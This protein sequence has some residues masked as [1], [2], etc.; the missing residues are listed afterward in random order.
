MLLYNFLRPTVRL[1]LQF[2]CKRLSFIGLEHLPNDK[3][4]LFCGSHSNSFLDALFLATCMDYPVY[5]LARGDAFRKPLVAKILREFKMLPIFRQSEGETD[6]FAKNEASFQTCQQLFLQNKK[7]LIYPEGICKHQREILPLKKGAATLVIRAWEAGIDLQIV[8]VGIS[9]DDYFKWGKK[10]DVVFGK[11]IQK[12][13]FQDNSNLNTAFTERLYQDMT[14]LF[15]SPHQFQNKA[16][17]NG[18]FSQILYY[19]GWCVNAP[20]YFFSLWLGEKLTKGT[21]F[22]DSAVLGIASVFLPIYYLTI[23]ILVYFLL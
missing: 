5:P 4:I 6:A 11:P 3:P 7:V 12:T 15:P 10:C 13:D 2:F 14:Q 17:F 1:T 21:V 16:L 19:L 22:H 20:L 8:P 9:Y 18:I 23:T